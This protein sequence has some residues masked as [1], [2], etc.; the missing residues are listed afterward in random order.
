[1]ANANSF[2]SLSRFSQPNESESSFRNAYEEYSNEDIIKTK[3]KDSP[4]TKIENSKAGLIPSRNITQDITNASN[5][6]Q[7]R[8]NFDMDIQGNSSSI[9]EMKKMPL[10][11][12]LHVHSHQIYSSHKNKR[13]VM[14]KKLESNHN[15]L[16]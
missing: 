15:S 5:I 14:N 12:D 4:L 2:A 9:I 11:T 8:R 16:S 7:D 10:E 6:L 1:M 13:Q 3:R